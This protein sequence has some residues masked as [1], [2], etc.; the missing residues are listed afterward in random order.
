MNC[1]KPYDY[2]HIRNYKSFFFDLV[3]KTAFIFSAYNAYGKGLPVQAK[4][5]PRDELL[6]KVLVLG[7][8]GFIEK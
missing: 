8:S 2:T 3:D 4:V 6:L 5:Q 1:L 7:L